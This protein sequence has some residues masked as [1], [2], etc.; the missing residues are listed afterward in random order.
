[1]YEMWKRQQVHEDARQM[2]RAKIL[3]KEFGKWRKRHMG[4]HDMVRRVDRQGD[5]LI[6]C[7][8]CSGY[9]RQK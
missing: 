3:G 1:M 6:W 4:G 7:R 5:V 8:K 2:S 9:A